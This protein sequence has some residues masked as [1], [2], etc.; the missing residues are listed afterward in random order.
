M[1][2][3]KAFTLLEFLVTLLIVSFA[4]LGIA[5]LIGN[6]L[7]YNQSAG[8]RSEAVV[9]AGDIIDRMRANRTAAEGT[10]PSPYTLGIATATP[11]CG[12]SSTIATCDLQIWRSELAT[13]FPSGTGSVALDAATGK[14]TVVVQWNDARVERGSS[15]Q[16]VTIET[17]L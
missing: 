12:V 9:L 4:L 17:R 14:V 16:T 10:N 1:R 13:S 11:T 15:T 2:R 3:Q 7:K 5:A 6:S 8:F